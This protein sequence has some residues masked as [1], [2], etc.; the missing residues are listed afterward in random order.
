MSQANQ[1]SAAG[2]GSGPIGL[3]E[4]GSD[5]VATDSRQVSPGFGRGGVPLPLLLLYLSFLVFFT[6]YVLTYQLPHFLGQRVVETEQEQ[7]M[8]DQPASST[9]N[10]D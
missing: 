2:P 8:Q 6:Y 1:D 10:E 3:S 4:L 7:T 9:T 5:S